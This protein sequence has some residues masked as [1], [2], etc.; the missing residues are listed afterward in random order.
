MA[1]F[2]LILKIIG[3]SLLAIIGIT[4]LLLC[5]PAFVYI[6]Y[7]NE[8]VVHLRLL[9]VKF[10]VLPKKEN[11][12]WAKRLNRA[13]SKHPKSEKKK[14][15]AAEEK[16]K[17]KELF[18][19]RGAAEAIS[20]LWTVT[21]LVCGSLAKI[22]KTVVISKF[23][24]N[25]EI[26]GDDAADAAL[27]YGKLCGVIYPSLSLVFQNVCK[28]KRTEIEVCPNFDKNAEHDKVYL[29][30]TLRACPIIIAV[31]LIVLFFRL[32]FT[33]VGGKI[34]ENMAKAENVDN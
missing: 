7:D 19:E 8:T 23:A 1:V 26:T 33:V 34:S 9:F 31:Q 15:E 18:G 24:L 32:L 29:N 6:E 28:Y 21:K 4:V 30:T 20:L 5:I 16:S 27:R 3:I 10:R 14:K 22:I 11:G 25:V 12:F 13:K 2:L 17:F